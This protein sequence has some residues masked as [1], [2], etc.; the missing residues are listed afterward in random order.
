M[1]KT[2]QDK[3]NKKQKPKLKL[4]SLIACV[5]N[6]VWEIPKQCT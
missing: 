5:G 4:V 3:K 1:P 2:K 6:F